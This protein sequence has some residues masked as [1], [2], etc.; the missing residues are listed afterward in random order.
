MEIRG[1]D[2]GDDQGVV[3]GLFEEGE[4]AL[5]K[6][7]PTEAE[8]CFDRALKV[9]P[10]NAGA[11][12]KLGK[13]YWAQGKTEDALNSLTRA[14]ELEPGDRDTVLECSKV[15]GALG[16]PDFSREV[17]E[18]YLEKNP[19]DEMVRSAMESLGD[20]QICNEAPGSTAEFFRR[21]G[22][23]QFERGNMA[24]AIACFEMAIENDPL[25]AEAYNNLGVVH[26]TSGRL[27]EALE[28]FYKALDLKPED[29]EILGNSAK[30]LYRAGHVTAAAEAYREYL[31]R[32][33]ED[34]EAW[35]E[36]ETV[37]RKCFEREWNPAGL[38]P[39][40]AQIYIDAAEKLSAAG[41]FTGAADAVERALEI[42]PTDVRALYALAT[43]HN[44][45]GQR[46]EAV[47]VLEQ[48]L[49]MDPSHQPSSELLSSIRRANGSCA[50]EFKLPQ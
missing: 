13:A 29:P 20:K 19:R 16:K 33:P 34:D 47:S 28:L 30:A 35:A 9:D 26:V 43:I 8:K 5:L 7:R 40:V 3:Q 49:K 18:S 22:E 46:E 32:D 27:T 17:L 25:L 45:I 42:D 31:R 48:A 12:R 24:H 4:A 37:I 2:G 44:G 1:W 11:H 36:F 50:Q 10:F 38:S 15:F 39:D 14:L 23:A 41:D 21:Q 6:N